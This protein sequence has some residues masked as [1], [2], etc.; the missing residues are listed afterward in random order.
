MATSVFGILVGLSKMSEPEKQLHIVE[1]EDTGDQFVIYTT[2][3]GVELDVR[4]ENEEPWFTQAQLANIFGVDVRTVNEHIQKFVAEGELDNSTIRDFRIVREEGGR[5][6]TRP[7]SHYGLDVAFYVGYRV[8]SGQGK[9]FRRWATTMLV[10]LATKGFVINA[11]KLKNEP[12]HF[13]DLRRLIQDIRASEANLYAEL[14]RIV[15]MCNDYDPGSKESRNFFALFQNRLLFAITGHSA[16]GILTSRAD[17]RQPNMGLKAWKGNEP[18][19]TDVLTAKNYLGD[20]ELEDLNRLVGMVLD[21]FEDQ[22]KRGFLVSMADAEAKLQEIFT[23][24]RR[25]MMPGLGKPS[26][27]AAEKHVKEQYKIFDLAR[28]DE[29]KRLA[30]D[31]LNTAFAQLAAPKPKKPRKKAD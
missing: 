28:R 25:L 29:R 14:R 21:F 15:S 23:V 7:I 19:Q 11:R 8:N 20:L 3:A 2:T 9:L 27:N 24:N 17:A 31:D 4:F 26:H 13:A 6:V 16:A 22:V 30:L 1:D 18:L 10:Q 5:R 12:D